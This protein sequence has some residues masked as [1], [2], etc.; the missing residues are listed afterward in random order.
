MRPEQKKALKNLLETIIE[1]CEP[2]IEKYD[3]DQKINA[4][5]NQIEFNILSEVMKNYPKLRATQYS[6]G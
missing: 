5:R 4:P 2:A 6:S 3:R 1:A